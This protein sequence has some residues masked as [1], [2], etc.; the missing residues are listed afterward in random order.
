MRERWL[1]CPYCGDKYLAEGFNADTCLYKALTDLKALRKEH[2]QLQK[3][4]ARLVKTAIR[5]R[6]ACATPAATRALSKV[7][8]DAGAESA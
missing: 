8:A 5:W 3:Y 2:A 6:K 7:L 1:K 4:W